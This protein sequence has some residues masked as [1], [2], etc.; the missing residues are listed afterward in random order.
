MYKL[1]IKIVAVVLIS[2]MS[3]TQEK[4]EANIIPRPN[5]ITFGRGSFNL[6]GSSAFVSEAL[7]SECKE[8][9][10]G[11]MKQL[12]TACGEKSELS[13]RGNVRFLY[14]AKLP[15]ESYRI[16]SERQGLTVFASDYNGIIYA[17]QSIKQMLPVS[18]YTGKAD[19]DDV[20]SIPCGTIN[21]SPRFHYRGL[22]L[23]C[24]RHFFSTDEVKKII[25]V[26]EIHKLN[27]LHWHL[28][29]DQGWRVEIKK[30][31]ELI[32]VGA[33]RDGTCIGKDF[34]SDDGITY[35]GFY[36]Q[37][38]LKDIVSYAAAKGI[39]IMPEI[40]L[41]GH[42]QAAL[43]SYPQLGC[44][45]GPYKVWKRWGVSNDVLCVGKE[46][47]FTFLEDVLSEICDIFPSEYIHIGGDECPTDCWK[48]CPACQAKI[49]SLGIKGDE[50]YSAEHYLQSYTTEKVSEFL[51][52]K[53]RKI[54][55]WDEILEGK[56]V[57]GA[58]VM[59]WR[60]SEGG[61][62]AALV[63][64]DAIMT[65]NSHFY[66]DHYQSKDEDNEPLAIGGYS[67][68]EHVYGYDIDISPELAGHILGVQANMWTEYIKTDSHLEYM[69]LPRLAALSEVQWC[70]VV[71]KNWNRFANDMQHIRIIYERLGYN[72]ATHMFDKWS[73]CDQ[74]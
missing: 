18:I 6:S 55:G 70:H 59:S 57:D 27:R 23:D 32:K 64:H 3:C 38:E 48:T 47:T 73:P 49:A 40:D 50:K 2:L 29:D 46:S 52:S 39:T 31:P 21:D 69:I 37:E 16:K 67:S 53:G 72:Y 61:V 15:E 22:M 17:I 45:G 4:N 9:V 42:M 65:P 11:F 56:I 41:P 43:S 62:N 13:D 71:N 10:K 35:G 74:A 58:T 33:Y 66:F 19:V 20:W 30:Y 36:T 1:N 7:P 28:T 60:G 68:V 5:E 26:M 34:E 25:D 8:Y 63:G 54:I 12:S 24:S 51:A 44:T 14:D